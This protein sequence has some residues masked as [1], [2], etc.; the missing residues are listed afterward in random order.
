MAKIGILAVFLVGSIIQGNAQVQLRKSQSDIYYGRLINTSIFLC[1]SLQ[2]QKDTISTGRKSPLPE[3][4]RV[5]L[6]QASFIL[7]IPLKFLDLGISLQVPFNIIPHY[8]F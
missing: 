1:Y 2:F 4:P 3:Y 8:Y 5:E 6:W 7:L